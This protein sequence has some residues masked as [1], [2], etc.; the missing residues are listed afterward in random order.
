MH[1]RPKHRRAGCHGAPGTPHD[2]DRTCSA[3][4]CDTEPSR[5]RLTLFDGFDAA[6]EG[7][8]GGAVIAGCLVSS[9]GPWGEIDAAE[10]IGR[11]RTKTAAAN[12]AGI[13]P[14]PVECAVSSESPVSV[15]VRRIPAAVRPDVN[16]VQGSDPPA[17]GRRPIRRGCGPRAPSVNGGSVGNLALGETCA[18]HPPAA[19]A[20]SLP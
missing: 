5:R 1:A 18:T 10:A 15:T 6:A 8:L 4:A 12:I 2:F 13:V 7:D 16:T 14:P 11:A 9:P 19:P 20:D 17:L 3:T